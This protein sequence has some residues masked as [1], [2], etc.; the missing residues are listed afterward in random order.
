M[1]K[2]VKILDASRIGTKQQAALR[3]LKYSM[4][5]V[6]LL[7]SMEGVKVPEQFKRSPVLRLNFSYNFGISDFEVDEKGIRATLSFNKIPFFCDIPWEAIF[8]MSV[9]NNHRIYVWNDTIPASALAMFQMMGIVPRPNTVELDDL[10]LAVAKEDEP[11]MAFQDAYEAVAEGKAIRGR[12]KKAA[13]AEEKVD[14]PEET[15][16][17]TRKR[18]TKK[19]ETK[20]PEPVKEDGGVRYGHLKLMD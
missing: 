19:E 18:R 16:K 1:D 20:M 10:D 12:R 14:S 5:M 17:K 13:S 9:E 11:E 8:A 4:I 3:W 15:P 2:D 6:H 7:P